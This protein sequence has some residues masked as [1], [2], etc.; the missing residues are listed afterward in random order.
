VKI[1]PLASRNVVRNWRRSLVTTLAMAFAGVIMMLFAALIEGML[2]AS[3]RN[4]VA[5]NLGD[6]QIHVTGYRDDQDL[7]KLITDPQSLV[8]QIQQAGF[9]AS[10]RLYGFGLAASGST[11]AGAQ[12]RGIYP[13]SE[14]TVTQIH[15]HVSQGQWLNTQYPTGVVLG[16]KL[17]RTLGVVPG[18]EV[19][20]V[21]QASDGAVADA[22]YQ[23][24]GVLKAVGD[25]VDRA[26]FFMLA[27]TFRELMVI[28]SG[29]H[30]IAIMRQDRSADL[31]LATE[32]IKQLAVGY[33]TR[34]WRQLQP[35]IARILDLADS[36]T[37]FMIIITYVAVAMVILNAMLMSV[38]E[39]IHE[40]GVMK[41]IGVTPWQITQ[42]V[43][44]ETLVQVTVAALLALI[45]GGWS[46]YYFQ[47]H[48]IDLTHL[49]SAAS[50]GGIALDP[51]W[52]AHTTFKSVM[53]PIG[54]LFIIAL[55]SVIYPAIKA[56]LIQPVKAIYYR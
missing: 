1:I 16:K 17:A 50:I 7:Y 29:A 39:H 20:I 9:T 11:S 41:A 28:P 27:D 14:A 47:Q 3:E 13:E 56:A 38:F 52:Y 51:I 36:Q 21:S 42:L 43:F 44:A 22:L 32:T 23:V 26:G 49:A 12:M 6:L 30:E 37:I 33:E 54:F 40:F 45:I 8:T 2:L 10:Q 24:I 19:I 5:M 25:E 53:M 55:L 18:D 35:V 48:G 4:A 34:N 46:S 15:Q 31:A